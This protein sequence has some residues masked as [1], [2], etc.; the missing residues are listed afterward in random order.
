MYKRQDFTS[1][2]G[3]AITLVATGRVGGTGANALMI[4]GFDGE[5]NKVTPQ[6]T[7]SDEDVVEPTAELPTVFTV[8]GNYPNPFNPTTNVR[9]DLPEQANVRIEVVDVLGRNVMTVAPQTMSAG[10]NKV[11]TIDAARLSSGTYFYRVVAE[12]ATRTF[13]QGSKFTLVK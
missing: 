7:T 9:F 13:V 4:V 8:H 11:I 5:G 3:K 10:A 2:S 6:V 1:Q 12:G